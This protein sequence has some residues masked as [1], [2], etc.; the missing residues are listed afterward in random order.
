M[1]SGIDYMVA[2]RSTQSATSMQKC[3]IP[4]PSEKGVHGSMNEIGKKKMDWQAFHNVTTTITLNF[5]VPCCCAFTKNIRMIMSWNKMLL[6]AWKDLEEASEHLQNTVAETI[7][8]MLTVLFV[9]P[10]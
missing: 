8:N 5:S 9:F 4:F 10:Q 1:L 3:K 6:T 7:S 2:F